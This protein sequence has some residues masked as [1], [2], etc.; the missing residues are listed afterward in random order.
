[1]FDIGIF[2]NKKSMALNYIGNMLNYI[3]N[4]VGNI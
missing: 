4:H 1:M 2:N 3:S